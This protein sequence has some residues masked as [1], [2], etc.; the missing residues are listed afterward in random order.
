M[1]ARGGLWGQCVSRVL[2]GPGQNPPQLMRKDRT[3]RG[4]ELCSAQ[5]NVKQTCSCITL[6]L[7]VTSHTPFITHSL[8]I[9]F[10]VS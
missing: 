4:L 3:G 2:Y 5:R 9:L 10:L 1:R 6:L 7:S 8:Q